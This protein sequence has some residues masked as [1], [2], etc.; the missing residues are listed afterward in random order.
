MFSSRLS[1][2]SPRNEL[3]RL[4]DTK[5]A[6]GSEIL[7]LTESNPTH[8]GIDYPADLI[9]NALADPGITSYDP[10]PRGLRSARQAVARHYAQRGY[11]VAIDDLVL[12]AST[13]EAYSYIFKLLCNPGDTV[14]CPEPSYPLFGFLSALEGV[15][16][17]SYPLAYDGCWH[18][19]FTA[20]EEVLARATR[21]RAILLV[22]PNNP[23]GSY[24]GNDEL[25][26]L[27]LISADH[28]LAIVSDEVFA[29]YPL[30]CESDR[31]DCL[32]AGDCP[33]LC[34]SLGGLSKSSGLPQ[35]KLGWILVGGPSH[36][37][38][39]ALERLETIAD[40]FLS[41][42]T[43]VQL[44]LGHL[45]D[46]QHGPNIGARIRERIRERLGRNLDWLRAK[47]SQASPCTLLAPEGGWYAVLRLPAVRSDEETA[48][49]LLKDYGTLVHPGFFFDFPGQNYLVTSL[50]TQPRTFKDGIERLLE[51]VLRELR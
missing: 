19:D 20:L 32:A 12:S 17:A 1:W 8:A 40:T 41:V 47:I 9:R 25:R 7:D 16:T 36:L 42:A 5:R 49:T 33:V 21:V 15:T 46:S 28:G 34:F 31:V 18:I 50:L 27:A 48:M 10:D 4:L 51:M 3:S 38:S 39:D 44:A 6:A 30:S 13:S 37:R 35:L 24:L 45:L 11:T 43:P 14:L 29:D 22:S 2:S 26:K 23:T